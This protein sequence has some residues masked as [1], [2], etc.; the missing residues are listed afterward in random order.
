M[1]PSDWPPLRL[2]PRPRIDAVTVAGR[3]VCHVIDDALLDPLHWVEWAS[4]RRDAFERAGHNAFPGNELRLPDAIATPIGDYFNTHLRDR[5]EARRLERHYARL[6]MVCL[7]PE[8]LQP[9]Q[10]QPHVDRL[11][12]APGHGIAASVLYLFRDASLGGTGFY[13]MRRS[14]ESTVAMIQDAEQLSPE[15]FSA[16][17]GVSPGYTTES[18][19][20]FERVAGVEA[21]WNRLIIYSGTIFHAGDIRHPQRL[22]DDPA[23][24]RLTLNGF[25]TYRRRAR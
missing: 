2:N 5:F 9:T 10:W 7:A 20:W 16:R 22:S 23:T 18:N 11:D 15:S 21:R 14:P 3:T 19:D 13:R 6:S 4:S 8:A 12:M 17:H 1:E 24:G 25:F